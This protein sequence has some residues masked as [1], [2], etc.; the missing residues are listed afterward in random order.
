MPCYTVDI[1]EEVASA[2][3]SQLYINELEKLLKEKKAKITRV[4]N[5]VS[6]EGWDNRGSWCDACALRKLRTS[7]DFKVRNLVNSTVK[8]NEKVTFGT[9][10]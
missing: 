5:K 4:G 8:E 6:I 1:K 3:D 10:H 9:G 2:R 7:A